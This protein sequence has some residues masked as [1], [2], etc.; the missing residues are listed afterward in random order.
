VKIDFSNKLLA[1]YGYTPKEEGTGFLS[2]IDPF[3]R[4]EFGVDRNFD[5]EKPDDWGP[6]Y[7]YLHNLRTGKM[8]Q[9]YLGRT[10][11]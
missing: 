6:Y 10:K 11:R 7:L 1:V 3:N 5:F 8:R 4:F 2:V 9:V